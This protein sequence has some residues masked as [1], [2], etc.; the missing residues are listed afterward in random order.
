MN[1]DLTSNC[2]MHKQTPQM[3]KKSGIQKGDAMNYLAFIVR[4]VHVC[5]E[6]Q[7]AE[8]RRDAIGRKEEE[9]APIVVS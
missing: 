4:I 5:V 9:P 8:K 1:S 6:K 7:S 3:L 2:I